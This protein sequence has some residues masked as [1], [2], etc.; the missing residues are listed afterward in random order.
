MIKP[1]K[2]APKDSGPDLGSKVNPGIIR[3]ALRKPIGKVGA[4]G[5][6][7]SSVLIIAGVVDARA[8]VDDMDPQEEE[9]A[10]VLESALADLN[11]P[12]T[13]VQVD[14]GGL[15]L[16]VD[17]FGPALVNMWSDVSTVYISRGDCD[18]LTM[19]DTPHPDTATLS[20]LNASR[21]VAHTDIYSVS[22]VDKACGELVATHLTASILIE[23]GYVPVKSV[24]AS[25]ESYKESRRGSSISPVVVELSTDPADCEVPLAKLV[26]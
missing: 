19:G 25:I 2:E 21:M 14:C 11:R 10:S 20:A 26:A 3:R 13:E 6:A 16:M 5:I 7:L 22:W 9:V 1:R 23:L 4:V 8:G 17:A 12:D 18:N 15:P 24:T